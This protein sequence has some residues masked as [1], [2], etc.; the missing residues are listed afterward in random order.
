MVLSCFIQELILRNAL[1]AA[2]EYRTQVSVDLLLIMYKV[3]KAAEG[4]EFL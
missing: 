2:K 1:G 4:W 3:Q